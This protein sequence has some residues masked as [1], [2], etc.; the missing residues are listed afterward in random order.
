MPR[1]P[2]P[3]PVPPSKAKAKAK[4]AAPPPASDDEVSF[5]DDAMH[6]ALYEFFH[7]K[8]TDMSIVEVIQAS[9]DAQ[10]ETLK[11]LVE[12][13]QDASSGV[14]A[15]AAAVT[16][17]AS[18]SRRVEDALAA[19]VAGLGALTMELRKYRKDR[20]QTPPQ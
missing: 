5:V 18:S 2:S 1:S 16:E 10:L 8:E 17:C 13:T 7:S 14:A 4:A 11:G 12:A 20:L 6:E 9:S 19:V 3:S 15:V